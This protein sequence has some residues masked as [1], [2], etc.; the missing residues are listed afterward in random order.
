MIVFFIIVLILWAVLFILS[1]NAFDDYIEP[2]NKK[3]YPFKD[4][5][6]MG[7]L[8]MDLIRYKYNTSYDH[9]LLMKVVEISGHK[10]GM[11]YL[12]VHFA[13]KVVYMLLGLL[14]SGIFSLSMEPDLTFGAFILG[15]LGLLFYLSD[16]ELEEKIKKRH[17]KIQLDFPEFLNKMTLL[18]NAGMTITAAWQKIVE[19]NQK[20]SPLYLELEQVLADICSGKPEVHAYEDFAKRCRMQEVSKFIS[21]IVQ[22][23]RKGNAE[24]VSILRLQANECWE[25]R[26]HA[27]RRLGEEAGTKMLFPMMIMFVAILIIVTLPAILAL[28]GI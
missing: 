3:T 19:D 6:P 26:K 14:L 22:N 27:A 21:V 1:R 25:M 9:K 16:S 13:N 20:D 7:F 5:L 10:F 4:L 28:Q 18:I 8:V 11:Y 2:L 23:L 17:L 24:L 12:R 15:F